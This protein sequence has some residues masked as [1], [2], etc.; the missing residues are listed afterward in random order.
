MALPSD[1]KTRK[2]IPMFSGL[3]AYFPHGLA[4]VAQL[5]QIAN[6]QHNPGEP[7]HWAKEKSADEMD[8]MIRHVTD[9]AIDL[10]H[11][12]DEGC[13]A[14]VKKA[15]RALADLERMH[16]AGINIFHVD[17]S[18]SMTN[19]ELVAKARAERPDLFQIGRIV[20]NPEPDMEVTREPES[21]RLRD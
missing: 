3:I 14:A 2:G 19:A 15:W 4:A 13:L 16:E 8:A 1:A 17:P 12:D 18:V 20:I 21:Y 7:L 10:K 9:Q 11:R 5:S 6:D